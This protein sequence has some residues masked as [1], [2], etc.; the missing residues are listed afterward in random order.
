MTANDDRTNATTL[1]RWTMFVGGVLLGLLVMAVI[2]A[3]EQK[4]R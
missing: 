1:A 4:G 2:A 3:V